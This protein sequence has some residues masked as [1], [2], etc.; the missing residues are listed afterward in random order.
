MRSSSR[1]HARLAVLA[2]AVA[3]SACGEDPVEPLEI[4]VIEEVEFAA[5]LGID[6]EDFTET[7]SGLY[8]MDTAA[9]TGDA[10]MAGD[11]VDVEY[12]LYYRSGQLLQTT[13]ELGAPFGFTIGQTNAIEGFHEGVSGMRVG[14]ERRLIIP[15]ELAYGQPGPEGILI[16]DVELVLLAPPEED[17]AAAL[18]PSVAH[19]QVL[20]D[21]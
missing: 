5:S 18:L 12:A 1:V 17:P 20:R 9:G 14:G 11:S 6:L 7:E 2:G 4:E 16:F 10:A 8:Y 19:R 15:P 3:L 13:A 21:P